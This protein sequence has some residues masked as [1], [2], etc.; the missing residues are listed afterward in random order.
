MTYAVTVTRTIVAGKV[1]VME[2]SS[3]NGCHRA[4][5][6]PLLNAI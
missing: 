4:L 1:R 5:Y 6:I 2:V 3:A